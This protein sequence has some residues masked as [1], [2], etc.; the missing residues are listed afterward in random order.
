[1]TFFLMWNE[2][3]GMKFPHEM[4][5]ARGSFS[6]E[7]SI[8]TTFTCKCKVK[9]KTSLLHSHC[10]FFFITHHFHPS[11]YSFILQSRLEL[12]S[13]SHIPSLSSFFALFHLSKSHGAC[14]IYFLTSH[15]FHPSWLSFIL[16]TISCLICA[17]M[18]HAYPRPIDGLLLRLQHNHISNN[19]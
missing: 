10:S 1:M 2:D 3:I 5:K 9:V 14:F 8:P 4:T 13:L 11:L 6:R 15:V 17:T 16:I 12:I 19:V 18:A 7:T